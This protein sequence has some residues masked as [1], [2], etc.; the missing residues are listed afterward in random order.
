MDYQFN[1]GDKVSYVVASAAGRGIRFSAREGKIESIAGDY[2]IVKSKQGRKS[3]IKL[4]NMRPAHVPNALTEA[5]TKSVAG[6][7]L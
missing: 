1:D 6:G 5:F 3:R 2:A 4:S 7:A